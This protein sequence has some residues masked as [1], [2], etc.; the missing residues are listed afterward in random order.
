M[1]VNKQTP[2]LQNL[3]RGSLSHS[4]PTSRNTHRLLCIFDCE[5]ERTEMLRC[6]VPAVVELVRESPVAIEDNAKSAAKIVSTGGNNISGWW[7][8]DVL[9]RK[10]IVKKAGIP[11]RVATAPTGPCGTI[12]HVSTRSPVVVEK[13][14]QTVSTHCRLLVRIP[15]RKSRNAG[16]DGLKRKCDATCRSHE[17]IGVALCLEEADI[18]FREATQEKLGLLH[19]VVDVTCRASHNCSGLTIR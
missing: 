15:L 9:C 7:R 4:R 6:E 1:V 3:F 16:T 10:E 2:S 14:H 18:G 11:L 12:A 17:C 19:L 8:W 5:A 13:T